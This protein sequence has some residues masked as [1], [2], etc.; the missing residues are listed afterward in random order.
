M[1]IRMKRKQLEWYLSELEGFGSPK[2]NLEQYTTS[3]SLCTDIILSINDLVGI[4]GK[5]IAD[6][7]CGPGMLLYSGCVFDPKSARGFE[8]DT[9]AVNAC[10][11]NREICEIDEDLDFQI[12]QTDVFDDTVMEPHYEQYDIVISNPPFGTKEN[13]GIDMDFVDVGIHLLKPGGSLF[14]LHKSST[15]SHVLKKGNGIAG[16][17]ATCIAQLNWNLDKTYG[18]HKHASK[19]IAVDLIRFEK[20]RVKVKGEEEIQNNEDQVTPVQNGQ[21][22]QNEGDQLTTPKSGDE[23]LD[24]VPNESEQLI[25]AKSEE[26][27]LDIAQNEDEK[28]FAAKK[29]GAGEQNDS[30]QLNDVEMKRKQLEWYLSELEGFGSPKINLEQYTTSASLCTDIILSINDLVGIRGKDIADLGCGPGMLLYS[31]CVF[32][33]KSAR[34]FE[35]DTDAVNACNRNREICEIDED[36]DFQIIQTDVFDDT[37]MEPHYEQYDIVI[38]NPPFGTK[39]NAG[40][41]MD[42]VDVGIHLLKPG[43][44]LFSLHKSST[45]SHV[46]KKGNGIA[47]V[48]ATCIAQLNW[49][50]DKT[51]GFHKHAS[52]DIAVDLIRF[53]KLRVKVKGE[54]EIQN[55]E[56]QVAPVQNGQFVQNEED[57]LTTPKSGDG[58]LDTVPNESEQLMTAKREEEQ[59]D[60][61]QNEDEKLFAA[62]KDAA[63][64]QNDSGQLNDVEFVTAPDIEY[65]IMM[66][67]DTTGVKV[68]GEEEIQNNEDQVTPVQ[69]GQF[70][71]NE[72]DQLTTP[73]SGDEQLDTVPNESEQLITAKSEEE[74]LDIAQNEDEKLFAAKK[75]GAGEQNDSGQLND[76]EF[77]TAPDIEYVIMMPD[78]ATDTQAPAHDRLVPW[79]EVMQVLPDE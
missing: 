10:N 41:D 16:V 25:T 55:N 19:D 53:E 11:R 79:L 58:Q 65:A 17:R 75:D 18:F 20:L 12:I 2:I 77:V 50:L 3:A 45:R 60:T 51:Y 69:N 73:K 71:Q 1:K 23:Q 13:A 48:R 57:Q 39:E 63:G 24:T 31:G 36:L 22:V 52:K 6:L 4:R 35:I 34:G 64:E 66:P 68:K 78:D 67:D 46:L 15:R 32:D 29:D 74:Q 38:S 43:G 28:L 8:I 21:F 14:S 33:P 72:G 76:V 27:Q 49:N 59:L 47:G 54:E 42:F 44:S 26:E 70:V 61:A 37:V 30:G 9:D 56:D 5:D 40:I 7:G 62:K